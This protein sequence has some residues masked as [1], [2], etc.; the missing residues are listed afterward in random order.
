MQ[1]F[2]ASMS[3]HKVLANH[4]DAAVETQRIGTLPEPLPRPR[5]TATALLLTALGL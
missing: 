4:K 2:F 1:A 5:L 3:L